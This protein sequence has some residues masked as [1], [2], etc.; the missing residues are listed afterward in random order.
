METKW[1]EDFVSLA[2]TRSFSRS[3][4]LR[5]VT[6]PAFS[7][8][9]QALEAWAGTDLVDR[10][11]YP[12]RLTPAG[13]TL[14]AQSLEMLQAL[15]STRAMLR[16]HSAAGQDVIEFAVPH[17]LAFTFFPAWV[18]SLR[19]KFGPIKSRL[20]A[21]N[22]HDAVMRLVEGGCD[23]FIGYHHASQPFQL[24][25]DRYEM[26][27]LGEEVLA[28][29]CKPDAAGEPMFK[30]PGRAGQPL[31]YLGYAPGAYLGR[32]TDLILKQSA[33][34]IHLDRVYETDMAEGLKVMALEGHG[35][36]FLP[37]SAVKKELKSR[38]LVNA[39]PAGMEGLEMAMDVRA[40]REKPMGKEAPKGTAQALWTYLAT[41]TSGK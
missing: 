18:S 2:E 34:A 14:Y 11:S 29:Y 20:I 12:T 13:E 10:S 6:Q 37:N 22:V 40:Y 35:V 27:T 8:R 25:A 41:H 3:A 26:V 1:L 33:T 9:I 16:G 7:R 24:D 19:E 32:V 23:I 4:Q 15:Q 28:P 30:L 38:R 39:A 36:A 17:T 5:H 21:L 31:P